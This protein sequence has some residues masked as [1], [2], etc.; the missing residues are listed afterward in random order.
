M[1]DVRRA[2]APGANRPDAPFRVWTRLR[3]TEPTAPVLGYLSDW[4]APEV[5]R[6]LNRTGGGMSLD[7]TLRLGEVDLTEWVLVEMRADMVVGGFGTGSVL[8]WSTNETLVAVAEQTAVLRPT[9]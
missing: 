5:L 2:V 1:V 6:R 7:T 9:D 8:M 4:V 3:G